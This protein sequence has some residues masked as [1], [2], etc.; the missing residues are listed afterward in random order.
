MSVR[1]HLIDGQ[2]D[3]LG[4]PG[5]GEGESVTLMEWNAAAQIWQGKGRFAVSTV[6]GADQ[7]EEGFV[8]R[9]RQQLSFTKHP[10]RGGEVA[11]EHSDFSDVRLSHRFLLRF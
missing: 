4:A 3:F 8:F 9:D 10:A 2:R 5:F 7:L 11:P 6:G 1:R